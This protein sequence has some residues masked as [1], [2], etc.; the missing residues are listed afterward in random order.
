MSPAKTEVKHGNFVEYISPAKGET[1]INPIYPTPKFNL[2]II[3][4]TVK[5]ISTSFQ[6]LV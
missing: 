6:W 4:I 2:G 1:L 3:Q 5:S